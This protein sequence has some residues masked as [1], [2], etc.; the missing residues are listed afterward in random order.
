MPPYA[1]LAEK[2]LTTHDIQDRMRALRAVGVPY[3]EAQ[4][5]RLPNLEPGRL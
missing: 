4:I 5:E 2:E 3:T 1:F